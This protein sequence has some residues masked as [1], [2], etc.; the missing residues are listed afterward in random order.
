M[1]LTRI[2]PPA[3]ALGML[4]VMSQAYAH[5]PVFGLGPHVLYK[6]GVEIAPEA[7]TA[8]Q[9]D[10]KASELELE[11]TYGLTGDWAVGVDLPYAFRDSD[12]N[13][14]SGTGDAAL[15]TK[16]NFISVYTVSVQGVFCIKKWRDNI[17]I[18]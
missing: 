18:P 17:V 7:R 14:N 10:N 13:R 9:G 4:V 16:V 15:F 3:I 6:G 11:L 1:K 2:S 12:G 8:K 5:D